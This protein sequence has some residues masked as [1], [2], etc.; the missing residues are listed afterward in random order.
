M[1]R[2][3][4][5]VIISFDSVNSKQHIFFITCH[6]CQINY[7]RN[8]NLHQKNLVYLLTF[9]FFCYESKEYPFH[10]IINLDSF[11]GQTQPYESKK[12]SF[13]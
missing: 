6:F 13:I 11:F 7:I 3:H 9:A 10:F 12:F 1:L 4:V 2:K 8:N 5:T